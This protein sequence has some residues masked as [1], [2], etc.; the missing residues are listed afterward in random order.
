MSSPISDSYTEFFVGYTV[1]YVVSDEIFPVHRKVNTSRDENI[2]YIHTHGTPELDFDISDEL[3]PIGEYD[4]T[5]PNHVYLSTDSVTWDFGDGEV[6]T[7]LHVRHKYTQPGIYTVKVILR[8]YDGRPRVS[9]YQQVIHVADF[10]KSEVKWE[11]PGMRELRCD[12]V[13]AGAPSHHLT[14]KTSTNA[15]Y[16]DEISTNHTVSL[17]ASGSN[18]EPGYREDYIN[19]KFA[20]FDPLWKFMAVD[21]TT[22]V[23]YIN[24][25]PSVVYIRSKLIDMEDGTWDIEYGYYIDPNIIPSTSIEDLEGYVNNSDYYNVVFD[26]PVTRFENPDTVYSIVGHIGYQNI[27]YLD[28]TAKV[29]LSR[30]QDPVMLFASLNISEDYI[31]LSPNVIPDEILQ[32]IEDWNVDVLP[33]KVMFNPATQLSITPTGVPDI[34]FPPQKY[35]NSLISFNIALVDPVKASILKSPPYPELDNNSGPWFNTEWSLIN[36]DINEVSENNSNGLNDTITV[37]TRGCV[38][39]YITPQGATGSY[40]LSANCMVKDFAYANKEVEAYYVAN[41]H[42]DRIF[43]LRPGYMDKI[44]TFEPQYTISVKDYLTRIYSQLEEPAPVTGLLS[45][46]AMEHYFA[47]AVDSQSAAW[48]ADTD[49]D[50]IIQI[51]RFGDHLDTIV[52]PQNLDLDVFEVNVDSPILHSGTG[53]TLTE[54]EHAYGISSISIDSNDNI[55]VCLSDL[56]MILKYD[57]I[58]PGQF[59][60]AMTKVPVIIPGYTAADLHGVHV[61]TDREDNVWV[62]MMHDTSLSTKT[63]EQFIIVKYS[64]TGESLIQPIVLPINIYPH[65]LIVD[66]F[67]NIWLSNT[68]PTNNITTGSIFHISSDGD[69]IKE[70]TEYIHPV[71]KITTRF[72]K[73]AQLTL[74]M[75]DNLW[76]SNRGNELLRM[77]TDTHLTNPQY[78]IER[79]V[80]CGSQWID[81]DESIEVHG[82][83]HAIEALSCDTDNRLV[84]VNNVSKRIYMFDA[85]DESRHVWKSHMDASSVEVRDYN[86]AP[87]DLESDRVFPTPGAPLDQNEYH[88]LQ[89]FGDWTGI[90]WIQ[91]YWKFSNSTRLIT[92]VSNTFDVSPKPK[93]IFKVNES[94]GM[95]EN[96]ESIMLQPTLNES[97]SLIDKIIAPALGG[98]DSDADTVGK[99]VYEKI[100][101]FNS[102][103]SDADTSNVTQFYS[104]CKTLG[105]D[106]KDFDYLAPAS[107]RRLINIF[108]IGYSKLKG[109]RDMTELDFNALGQESTINIGKNRGSLIDFESYQVTAGLPLISREL[110]NNTYKLIV[111]MTIKGQSE[112][113]SKYMLRDFN[114]DWGWRLSFPDDEPVKHYYDFYHFIPNNPRVENYMSNIAKANTS[115]SNSMNSP[116]VHDD[117]PQVEGVIDWDNSSTTISDNTL[118]IN[119][120]YNPTTD[121]QATNPSSSTIESIIEYKLRESLEIDE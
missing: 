76:I 35:I 19:Y 39:R 79:A 21:D 92:G 38:S 53:E 99:V 90:R 105:F 114:T 91:K 28:D 70:V 55:W 32:S 106:V 94:F 120:F 73:P 102:N 52:L 8:D 29:Y 31:K 60:R 86:E 51:S 85:K 49:R 13:P 3:R 87:I 57:S 121:A 41:M 95:S 108:S 48:I 68:A 6:K 82:R 74:D 104:L 65:D 37:D 61:E 93:D 98:K 110:F 59:E 44:Y 115:E 58:S 27:R 71:T 96:I 26:D 20:Q 80:T 84:V 43:V 10:V 83:R 12:T 100:S 54:I 34:L 64:P 1:S 2:I 36:V 89:A 30:Q 111:P 62:V 112:T 63:P 47:I 14:V 88:I 117:H 18:S 5:T 46:D 78:T 66:G 50:A 75:D 72:D 109:S 17:Y 103:I 67:N 107:I 113:Q 45:D 42:T 22:P 25:S 69:I 23:Q 7:G 101:N 77:V 56:S 33:I 15:R 81:S 119:E 116:Y 9:K 97:S 4:G 118:N 24:I 40:Q 11:T 16:S